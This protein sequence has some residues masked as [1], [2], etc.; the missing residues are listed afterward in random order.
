MRRPAHLLVSAPGAR[1]VSAPDDVAMQ[2]RC[3]HCL[4]EQYM[5]SVLEVSLGEAACTWCGEMSRQMTEVQYRDALSIARA[6]D[7]GK[8]DAG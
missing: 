2:T 8:R 4:K 1:P 5:L 6:Q 7:R 3:L